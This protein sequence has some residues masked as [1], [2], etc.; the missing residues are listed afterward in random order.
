M[1]QCGDFTKG[2]GTGGKSIYGEKVTKYIKFLFCF[3]SI[4][5]TSQ[6]ALDAAF[7]FFVQFADENF[8]LQHTGPGMLS[9]ANSGPNTNGSQFFITFTRTDWLDGKHVVFGQVVKGL[10]VLAKLARV[11]TQGGTTTQPVTIINSGEIKVD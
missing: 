11:G 9:M 3:L 8:A 1:A 10:E 2:D 5:I 7:F 6:L 4:V